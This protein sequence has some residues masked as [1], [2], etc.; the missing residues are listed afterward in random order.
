MSNSIDAPPVYDF[1]TKN[2]ENV[3]QDYMSDIWRD[4]WATLYQTLIFYLGEFGMRIPNLTQ[5]QINS[6]QE[7]SIG[8]FIYNTTVDAPQVYTAAGW[9]TFTLF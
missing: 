5:A 6:I 2:K 9:K 7:P 1:L 4:Y 3:N 8:Q